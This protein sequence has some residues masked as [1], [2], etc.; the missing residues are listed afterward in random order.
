MSRPRPERAALLPSGRYRYRVAVV[1]LLT[2]TLAGCPD[3]TTDESSLPRLAIAPGSL[4]VSGIS[5]GG[6]MAGQFHVAHSGAVEAPR[7]SRRDRTTAP[8]AR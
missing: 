2:A 7:Y 8:K 4:T 3:R 1:I 5:A 6:Y